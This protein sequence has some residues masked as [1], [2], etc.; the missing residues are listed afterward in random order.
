MTCGN[1]KSHSRK[2]PQVPACGNMRNLRIEN[3]PANG[4]RECVF[5]FPQ[6]PAVP[7]NLIV[8]RLKAGNQ[9]IRAAIASARLLRTVPPENRDVLLTVVLAV[10][11]TLALLHL[12]VGAGFLLAWAF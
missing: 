5:Q 7:A 10:A 8:L 1:K 3:V 4:A 6:I 9:D 2:F 11:S 12:A